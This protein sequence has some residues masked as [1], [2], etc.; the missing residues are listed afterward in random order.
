M[1]GGRWGWCRC[2]QV[3]QSDL[4]LRQLALHSLLFLLSCL[5]LLGQLLVLGSSL[6]LQL[7]DP[8]VLLSPICTCSL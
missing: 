1:A 7:L 3:V 4:Q 2:L 6:S 8:H 5:C